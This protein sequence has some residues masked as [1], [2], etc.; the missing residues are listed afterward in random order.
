[1]RLFYAV[2]KAC[3]WK[4]IICKC[5]CFLSSTCLL[6]NVKNHTQNHGNFFIYSFID[7]QSSSFIFN[8]NWAAFSFFIC[9]ETNSYQLVLIKP[10]N[11]LNMRIRLLSK[12]D[13]ATELHENQLPASHRWEYWHVHVKLNLPWRDTMRSL[14]SVPPILTSFYLLTVTSSAQCYHW[15]EVL[16]PVSARDQPCLAITMIYEVLCDA[17]GWAVCRRSCYQLL[18]M[19]EGLMGFGWRGEEWG[20]PR[21][22]CQPSSTGFMRLQ[23]VQGKVHGSDWFQLYRS[24]LRKSW[25]LKEVKE[26]HN[27]KKKKGFCSLFS[28]K[29]RKIWSWSQCKWGR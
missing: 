16:V 13:E 8:R 25:A 6:T 12:K 27:E 20:D 15:A 2:K 14:E 3:C 21:C 7:K 26:K 11:T 29:K 10:L 4:N 5:F 23:V 22:L 24:A 19:C 1:M 17:G 18:G 9:L 28:K